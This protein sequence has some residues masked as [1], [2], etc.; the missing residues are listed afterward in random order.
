MTNY[1]NKGLKK[2]TGAVKETIYYAPY[3]KIENF[4]LL[5]ECVYSGNENLKVCINL[6][7]LIKY[8]TN[9]KEHT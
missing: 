6:V 1:K 7:G 2:V 9:C 8:T 4:P 5:T 3:T